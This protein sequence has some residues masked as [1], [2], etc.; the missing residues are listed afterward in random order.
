M[1][2]CRKANYDRNMKILHEDFGEKIRSLILYP[3]YSDEDQDAFIG[4]YSH[5]KFNLKYL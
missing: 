5:L 4:S 3:V 2:A 1:D